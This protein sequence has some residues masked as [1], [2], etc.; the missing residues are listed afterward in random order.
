MHTL[1]SRLILSHI[2]PLVL[3]FPFVAAGLI[4]LLESQILLREL[5][6]NLTEQAKLIVLSLADNPEIWTENEQASNF[7]ASVSVYTQ[8]GFF[9]LG[10]DG[11]VL[12]VGQGDSL[13]NRAQA[14]ELGGLDT[15]LTGEASVLVTYGFFQPRVEVL[16]PVTDAHEN[17]LGVVGVTKTLQETAT[18]FGRFRNRVLVI[19]TLELLLAALIG[20]WLSVRLSKPISSSVNAVIQIAE[21][22]RLEHLPIEGPTEIRQLSQ[23]INLL[24]ERLRELEDYRRHALA[25]IV[26]ELGRPLGAIQS[27][28]HVLRQ[29]IGQDPLI[30]EELLL[31]TE[32][33]VERMQPILD[34]LA[35]LHG[36]V[37]GSLHL[38]RVPT[39][40]SDWL[41][42]ILLT[43][44]AAALDK[45]I[46]W[47]AEIPPKLPVVY[48]DPERMSQVIGNLLSNAI[49]YTPK[50]GVVS[51]TA[52]SAGSEIWIKV[53]DSGPGIPPEEQQRIFEP[54]YRSSQVRRFPQGLG[55]GLTIA[56]DLV[57]A[58]G[59]RI[60]LESIPG[61]GATFVIRLPVSHTLDVFEII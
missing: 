34:D 6:Q 32:E 16:V 61:E 8:E 26:H 23:A 40:L 2:L 51:L 55:L 22:R 44:R 27:A 58:H 17:L 7:I 45:E 25:N 15:A 41:P 11:H 28:L 54:F 39:K 48:I 13:P 21:G 12:A 60:E 1:R 47:F 5:S 29:N 57:E 18:Q 56:R 50:D 49:K 3:V 59:G 9:L 43:W 33:E 14:A 38:N 31:G 24:A 35:Q 42:S 36:Q 10:P 53:G 52:G 20:S 46:N 19:L 30:Q 37:T 4:Y